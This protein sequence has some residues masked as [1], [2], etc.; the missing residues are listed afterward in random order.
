MRTAFRL[1]ATLTSLAVIVQVGFAGYGAFNAIDKADDAASVTKK[2]IENGFDPH[3]AL[4]TIV[5]ALM[6]IL[7]LISVFGG[8]IRARMVTILF[9]LGIVQMLLAWGATGAA[10]VGFLHGV[11]ALAIAGIAGS[12]AGDEWRAVRAAPA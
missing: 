9:V 11:N 4:G 1:V 8:R 3:G 5:V 6:L 7:V 12:L 2:T 10:W